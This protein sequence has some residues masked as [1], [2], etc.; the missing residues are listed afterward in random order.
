MKKIFLII[1][2]VLSFS[3]LFTGCIA[4]TGM[5]I[6]A[7]LDRDNPIAFRQN[8]L[9]RKYLNKPEKELLTKDEKNRASKAICELKHLK[10]NKNNIILKKY[11]KE[12]CKLERNDKVYFLDWC[13]NCGGGVDML[14]TSYFIVRDGNV[15]EKVEIEREYSK[16]LGRSVPIIE[17]LH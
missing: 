8:Q 3:F 5:F 16:E 2:L 11:A 17:R 13:M 4:E 14:A 10:K 12:F 1:S 15:V 6:G 9:N 7:L